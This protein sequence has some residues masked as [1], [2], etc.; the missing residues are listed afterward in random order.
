MKCLLLSLILLGA[1]AAYGYEFKLQFTPPGGAQG[2]VVAGYEFS[3]NAV[4]GNCSYYTVSAGS[5]RG[6]HGTRTNHYNTCSWDLFGSLISLTPVTN[7][8][9]APPPLSTTGTEIV[10]ATSGTSSTGHDTRGFGFVNTPSSH[11]TWKTTN[12]GYAVIPY[13]VYT[14]TATLISDGDFPLD[15]DGATVV[16][17]ISGSY[18]TPSPGTATIS[19]STCGSSVPA[20]STCSV[21]ISYDP[22]TIKC[23][24]S[25]Y[26]YLYTRIDLSLVTDA[27]ANID[28]TEGFT[29]TGAPMCDD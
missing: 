27:G 29:I 3:S 21:T 14:I 20:G 26:G 25:P 10:Y 8:L 4:V 16:S 13:A 19:G 11:Y 17:S 6:G 22:T 2:L 5:G 15:F 7:A 9:V 12:G 24:N 23:T 28:F 1:P 18:Y